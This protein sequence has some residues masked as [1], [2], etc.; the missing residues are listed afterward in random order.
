MLTAL[1]HTGGT[2]QAFLPSSQVLVLILG[3]LA[4]EDGQGAAETQLPL[5]ATG[6]GWEVPG[7]PRVPCSL[8]AGECCCTP[9]WKELTAKGWACSSPGKGKILLCLETKRGASPS[10]DESTAWA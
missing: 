2:G 10:C 8:Q 4:S 1:L 5:P 9:A 3:E 7:D 6:T